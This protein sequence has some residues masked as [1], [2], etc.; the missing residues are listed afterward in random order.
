MEKFIYLVSL[1][2]AMPRELTKEELEDIEK[3][4]RELEEEGVDL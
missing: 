1:V 4:S 2:Q 3:A